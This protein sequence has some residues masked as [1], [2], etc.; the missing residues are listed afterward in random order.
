MRPMTDNTTAT[1]IAGVFA[2]TDARQYTLGP[3]YV[4]DAYDAHGEWVDPEE[5]QVALWDYVRSGN[6]DIRLQHNTD[7]VAGEWVEALSWPYPVTVPMQSP[8][9]GDM[10][11]QEFP[12]G[13]VFMGVVWEDWAW[14]M[15]KAGKIRGYSMG[16]QGQRVMVDLPSEGL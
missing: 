4:P 11:D 2:K 10:M 7:V 6:R 12:A 16:G 15:V 3:W 1:K 5:L 14:N 13:T 8:D 9:N